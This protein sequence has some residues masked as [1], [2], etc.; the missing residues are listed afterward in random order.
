MTY[1]VVVIGAGLGGYVWAIRAA[2]LGM[3]VAIFVGRQSAELLVDAWEL[4]LR[5]AR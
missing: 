5:R 1:D 2:R 4:S 3:K